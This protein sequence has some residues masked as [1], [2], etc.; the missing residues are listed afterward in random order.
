MVDYQQLTGGLKLI[1]LLSNPKRWSN[2]IKNRVQI[3]LYADG[4]PLVDYNSFN[5]YLKGLER[6]LNASGD[7]LI[8]CCSCG[9][10]F[11]DAVGEHITRVTYHDDLVE[12]QGLG[13]VTPFQYYFSKDQ[14]IAVVN[15]LSKDLQQYLSQY[16]DSI[17]GDWIRDEEIGLIVVDPSEILQDWIEAGDNNQ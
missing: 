5:I 7:Y 9:Y 2:G 13:A 16:R 8:V 3:E 10:A 1:R 6:S 14:Y 12:W 17:E 4:E 15:Q 11:C